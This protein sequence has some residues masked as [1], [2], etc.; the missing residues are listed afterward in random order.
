MDIWWSD[1]DRSDKKIYNDFELSN[2]STPILQAPNPMMC[3]FIN[4]K[5]NTFQRCPKTN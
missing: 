3:I 2:N 5:L 1:A 4:A